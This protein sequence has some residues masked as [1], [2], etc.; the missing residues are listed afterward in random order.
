MAAST[1]PVAAAHLA[2]REE[3]VVKLACEFLDHRQLH[4]AQVRD[5]FA[6]WFWTFVTSTLLIV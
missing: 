4:I 3:D 2:I 6:S 1:A 5:F